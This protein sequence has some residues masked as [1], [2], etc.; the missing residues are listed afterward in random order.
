MTRYRSFVTLAFLG[1]VAIAC[2]SGG[3]SGGD[4]DV[5]GSIDAGGGTPDAFVPP[6]DSYSLVWGPVTVQPGDENTQCVTLKL[7]NLSQIHVGQIHNALEGGSHHL[8]VYRTND[9]TEITTPIDCDPFV[10]TFDPERGSPIM[11]TQKHIETLTL[12]EGVAFTLGPEQMIRLE[13]HFVN[14]TESAAEVK[15]TSTFVPMSDAAFQYEADFLFIGDVS[16][17]LPP[18]SVSTVGPSFLQI[19]AEYHGVNYFGITGHTHKLGLNVT[20]HSAADSGDPGTS[21]YDHEDWSWSEPETSYFTPA[22]KL[23][24]G[25]GFRFACD[26][27]NTTNQSVGFGESVNDEMC[28]FWAY[29]YPSH[30]SKVC[31]VYNT[32]SVCCPGND[33][34]QFIQF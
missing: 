7:G 29:Y 31:A 28:F 4:D 3:S 9:T 22:F 8:I 17:D 2:N 19:P 34:C 24:D 10:D 23:P 5:D 14:T 21:I 18:N 32:T 30:G 20:I 12:P 15:A 27:N 13:M 1:M 33:L 16:I 26:Y 25:G 6:A 11:V